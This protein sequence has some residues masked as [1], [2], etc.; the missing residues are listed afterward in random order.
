MNHKRPPIP[1]IVLL[2]LALLT[3]GYFAIR[4]L[5]GDG[6]GTL[7]ASGTIETVQVAI[8]PEIGGK[9]AEVYV[10]EGDTVQA[11][12]PLFRLD[13][14]LLQAQRAVAAAN[15]DLARAALDTAQAQYE[16][17]VTS[18]W[19]ESAASRTQEWRASNPADYTLPSWY[20][21][22]DE[23]IAAGEAEWEAAKRAHVMAWET[24]DHLLARP[25]LAE[26]QMAE[27]RLLGARAAFLTAQEALSR[28][29]LASDS[30]DIK[31]IAQAAYDAAQTELQQAQSAYDDL[32]DDEAA[33]NALAA[34]TDLAVAQVRLDSAR[35]RLLVLQTG[36][37]SPRVA[38][39][40][41]TIEQASEAASQAEAAL[42]LLDVQLDK[43]TVSAPA[44]GVVLTRAVEPGE[45]VMAGAR[46]LTLGRLD[47]L[48][49]T[50]YVPEDRYGEL[51]L[52]QAATVTVDSFPGVTFSASVVQIANQAEFTPRNVQT[53]EGRSG[54]V[55]AVK[56]Q[57]EDP[58]GKLKP[59]MPADV[60]FA[61]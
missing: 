19:A 55:Y 31:A 11:G 54:T 56:L 25:E 12:D 9:V 33:Q 29:G 2:V 53:V 32:A 43:L 15:L 42:S 16:L 26:F 6:G 41:A 30:V 37:D 1:V 24:L 3:A 10:N 52:G 47:S 34:R 44:D 40:W 17:T 57:V 58:D 51:S 8:A 36:I 22:R 14:T 35:D 45:V 4:S 38:V 48:T 50:V 28:A 7:S 49:I 18:A 61:E 20:F 23:Q 60:V 39:S 46:L 21:S 5:G 59:G 13:D 27:A